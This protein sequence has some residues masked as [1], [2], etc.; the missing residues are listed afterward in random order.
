MKTF[1]K[2]ITTL[3]LSVWLTGCSS[4]LER[5]PN[6]NYTGNM[7]ENEATYKVPYFVGNNEIYSAILESFLGDRGLKKSLL[8]TVESQNKE[9]P[10]NR[11]VYDVKGWAVGED[12]TRGISVTYADGEADYD[13][14]YE[15]KINFFDTH[16][17]KN[18]LVYVDIERV[19][20]MKEISL[21]TS[22]IY[23]GRSYVPT[24]SLLDR[25]PREMPE[26]EFFSNI[27]DMINTLKLRIPY[28]V[29]ISGELTANNDLETSLGNIQRTFPKDAIIK[30]GSPKTA[31]IS[32]NQGQKV[33][34]K[35]YPYKNKTK[36]SYSLTYKYHLN[37]KG[38]SDSDS[39]YQSK[40]ESSLLKVLNK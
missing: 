30:Y 21:K 12:G 18:V 32:I 35:L 29:N 14:R 19:G 38:G 8:V 31:I 28:S 13:P 40:I 9:N 17:S 10:G 16:Y 4:L 26:E 6:P 5:G 1:F 39:D 33:N 11:Y 36:V 23:S 25:V 3:I 37:E 34:L 27:E 15:K 7:P 2:L 22:H 24:F 20:G